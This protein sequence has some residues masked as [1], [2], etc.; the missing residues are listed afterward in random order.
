MLAPA[1]PAPA[2][3]R[4]YTA[5]QIVPIARFHEGVFPRPF[6][7]KGASTQSHEM[8]TR[9]TPRTEQHVAPRKAQLTLH[10]L[11]RVDLQEDREADLAHQPRRKHRGAM[12][13]G[14]EALCEAS[15]AR[16][17]APHT[18]P[19]TDAHAHRLQPNEQARREHDG[20]DSVAP[21]RAPRA[22][23]RFPSDHSRRSPRRTKCFGT[24]ARLFLAR[25]LRCH[26]ACSPPK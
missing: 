17:G 15:R 23:A 3:P 1:L 8:A 5:R 22:R 14:H 6:G 7:M 2:G 19:S 10:Q 26:E 12:Q 13:E 24:K 25:H 20:D 21:E 9:S 4:V 11:R 16:W 18:R